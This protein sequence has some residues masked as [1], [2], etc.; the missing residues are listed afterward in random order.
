VSAFF[1]FFTRTGQTVLL[2]KCP[3]VDKKSG[4]VRGT[5]SFAVFPRSP[6]YPRC[7]L[8]WL[9]PWIIL[10]LEVRGNARRR[11]EF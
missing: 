6:I 9:R 1:G 8:P 3:L 5:P 10:V 2:S 4:S 7:G 11:P